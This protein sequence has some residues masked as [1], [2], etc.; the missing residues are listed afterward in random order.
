[1]SDKIETQKNLLAALAD[2]HS[3]KLYKDIVNNAPKEFF[4]AIQEIFFN[5]SELN[6]EIGTEHLE[7]FVQ[8]ADKV[9]ELILHP[10][11]SCLQHPA[12]TRLGIKVALNHLKLE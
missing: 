7:K 5:I 11:P 1:M 6:I 9:E 10:K 3:R 12:L 2:S 4:G 8:A